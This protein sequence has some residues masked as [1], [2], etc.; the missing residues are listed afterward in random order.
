MQ[1]IVLHVIDAPKFFS[2]KHEKGKK[3]LETGIAFSMLFRLK[4]FE[5]KNLMLP[6][7]ICFLSSLLSRGK[8]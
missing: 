1:E 8:K 5:N 3:D 2:L 4:G 6:K 7:T